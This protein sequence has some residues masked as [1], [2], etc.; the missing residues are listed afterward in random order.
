MLPVIVIV[1]PPESLRLAPLGIVLL[2]STRGGQVA[3]TGSTEGTGRQWQQ[4]HMEVSTLPSWAHG[5]CC[6]RRQFLRSAERPGSVPDSVGR[7][8]CEQSAGPSTC[9]SSPTTLQPATGLAPAGSTPAAGSPLLHPLHPPCRR[10]LAAAACSWAAAAA[11]AAACPRPPRRRPPRPPP[12]HGR[13]ASSRQ[14]GRPLAPCTAACPAPVPARP[15][16]A[17]PRRRCRRRAAAVRRRCGAATARRR[18]RRQL[19]ARGGARAPGLR[20][21]HPRPWRCGR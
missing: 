8:W 18:R 14:D 3:R 19:T 10:R 17:P 1:V 2:G 4:G 9:A 13:R 16:A 6:L 21:S 5:G 12:L 11:A 7:Q 15:P 20:A